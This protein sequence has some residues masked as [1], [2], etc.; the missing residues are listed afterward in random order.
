MS[1][2]RIPRSFRRESRLFLW[3]ALLL[4]LFL[5]VLTLVFFRNSVE[6]G[7]AEAE[8]RADEIL[9]RVALAGS[10][11]DATEEALERGAV[12]PDVAYLAIYDEAGRRLRSHGP[13]PPE[14]PREL[15]APRPAAGRTVHEWH[16]SPPL[17]VTTFAAGRR[18]F[19]I[20]LDPGPGSALQRY[21]SVLT[22]FVPVAG[23]ALVVLAALY[24]RSLLQPYD[25]LL[26]AAGGAV[27]SSGEQ[28]DERS[29]IE[30]DTG[31]HF[32]KP[33]KYFLLVDRSGGLSASSNIKCCSK[34]C[35]VT[36]LRGEGG[37]APAAGASSTWRSPSSRRSFSLRPRSAASDFARRS[38]SSGRSTVVRMR[39]I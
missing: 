36:L 12:E 21:A 31:P 16:Q 24:L 9:R 26:E 39:R 19:S 37:S 7:R 29:R 14:S 11:Q 33:S 34:S 1:A 22:V 27:P 15:P 20:A 35:A 17:L 32:P 4:I 5:N 3:V 23:L 13:G 38:N 28:G 8:R 25:R 6:W 2:S 10:R 18:Y 30:Q